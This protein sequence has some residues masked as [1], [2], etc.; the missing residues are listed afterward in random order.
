MFCV[1]ATVVGARTNWYVADVVLALEKLNCQHPVT[2]V[3]EVSSRYCRKKG[4]LA[5]PFLDMMLSY[6][7]LE[8]LAVAGP[9][10]YTQV[11][12]VKLCAW[13]S[14]AEGAVA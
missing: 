9:V 12:T 11:A 1:A 6:T 8:E 7:E 3:P 10:S 14:A 2:Q 13:S 5:P 4:L